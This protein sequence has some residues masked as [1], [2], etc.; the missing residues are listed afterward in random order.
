MIFNLRCVASYTFNWRI[1]FQGQEYTPFYHKESVVYPFG[2][3]FN[4]KAPYDVYAPRPS[5]KSRF[6]NRR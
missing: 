1:I 6:L 5:V 3:D 4:G 2:N